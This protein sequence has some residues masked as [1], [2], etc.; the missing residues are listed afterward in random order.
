MEEPSGKAPNAAGRVPVPLVLAFIVCDDIIT[1]EL[2][3]KKTIVGAFGN[4]ATSAFPALHP[5]LA[6]F[7][8][9]ANGHGR[10]H[11]DIKL[12]YA[13]DNSETFRI[14]GDLE[15]TDPR[16]V[17]ALCLNFA[18]IVIKKE[19][20]YRFQVYANGELLIERRFVASLVKPEPTNEAH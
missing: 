7:L 10:V 11:V 16:A 15:F 12:V 3:K 20:E 1:D 5:K 9:L 4:I 2:T 13:S 17:L 19:G 6:L 8:E 18:N 14:G